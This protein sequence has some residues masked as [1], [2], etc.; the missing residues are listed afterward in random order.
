MNASQSNIIPDEFSETYFTH[1]YFKFKKRIEYNPNLNAI[2]ITVTPA[3]NDDDVIFT[4]NVVDT[5]YCYEMQY[6]VAEQLNEWIEENTSE[7]EKV[8]VMLKNM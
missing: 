2:K 4:A 1:Q 3:H 8:Y 5:M 7:L 6:E